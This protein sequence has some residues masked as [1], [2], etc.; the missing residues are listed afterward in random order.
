MTRRFVGLPTPAGPAPKRF[1][2]IFKDVEELGASHQWF[3]A[4]TKVAAVTTVKVAA[5]NGQ[6]LAA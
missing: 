1:R 3:A 5:R 4:N 2:P 6:K